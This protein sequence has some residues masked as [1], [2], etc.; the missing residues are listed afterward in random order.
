MGEGH[1]SDSD[2]WALGVLIWEMLHGN[3]PF[4]APKRAEDDSRAQVQLYKQILKGELP[5]P[6]DG[7]GR[8]ITVSDSAQHIVERLLAREPCERIGCGRHCAGEAK[9]HAFFA[10]AALHARADWQR[11]QRK[12]VRA[13]FVPEVRDAFDASCCGTDW[14][15][16]DLTT[17]TKSI[18]EHQKENNASTAVLFDGF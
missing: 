14:Q 2:Y 6:I 8:P 3:P 10:H 17:L 4:E 16:E 15:Q 5:L 9:R 13:P 11:L 18:L 1:S 12:Q 7:R